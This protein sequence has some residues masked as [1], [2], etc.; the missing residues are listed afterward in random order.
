M[1][2]TAISSV[3]LAITGAAFL[4]SVPTTP[5]GNWVQSTATADASATADWMDPNGG[6]GGGDAVT[7][8]ANAFAAAEQV[9][10]T[11]K[12][13]LAVNTGMSVLSA[14]LTGQQVNVLA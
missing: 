7:L 3:Q 8:A 12:N 10:M 1:S 11:N 5:G 4:A 13:S 2:I 14:Q 9:A 6:A